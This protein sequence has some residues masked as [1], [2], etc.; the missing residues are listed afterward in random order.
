MVKPIVKYASVLQVPEHA[1]IVMDKAIFIASHGR[2]GPVW[3]DVPVDVQGTLIDPDKLETY[4]DGISG[5]ANDS[6]VTPNTRIELENLTSRNFHEE[7]KEIISRLIKAERPVIFAGMGVRISGMHPDFLA[8]VEILKIPVVTGWNAHDILTN[9]SPFYSGRPGT[10][11]DRAGNFTVQ[12]SDFLLVLGSRL[13]IRQVSYNWKSFASRAWKVMI[14][15]DEA[16][17]NKPTL[18]ID[19]KVH[20]LLQDFLPQF[21][22]SLSGYKPQPAHLKYLKWCNERVKN[23]L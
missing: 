20:A 13:N 2:P 9:D 5:L 6:D 18:S 1:R 19:L 21:I 12:N 14:D 22:S 4:K 16:E 23:T 11:G 8:L 3:I 17:L 10:V 7:I 15:A